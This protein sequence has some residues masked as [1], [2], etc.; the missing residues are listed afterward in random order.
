MLEYSVLDSDGNKD[1][2]VAGVYG[3][4][5]AFWI[6]PLGFSQ[7]TE[8]GGVLLPRAGVVIEGKIDPVLLVSSVSAA[9]E[10]SSS[11]DTQITSVV[12]NSQTNRI[13]VTTV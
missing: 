13:D 7:S 1:Y 8:T 9:V 12:Y 5:D 4:V 11:N 3:S 10:S 6:R 2:S